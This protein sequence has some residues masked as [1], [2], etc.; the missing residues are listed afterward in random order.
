MHLPFVLVG[1]PTDGR[2]G[3]F[4]APEHTQMHETV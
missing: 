4:M 1:L 3:T 2:I